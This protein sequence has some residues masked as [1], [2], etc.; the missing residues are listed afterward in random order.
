MKL[1]NEEKK[2]HNSVLTKVNKQTNQIIKKLNLYTKRNNSLKSE[3]G[4]NS[5]LFKSPKNYI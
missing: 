4:K 5:K 3:I 2:I 1:F